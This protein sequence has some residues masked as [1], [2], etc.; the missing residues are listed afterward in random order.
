[1]DPH[2]NVAHSVPE[3]ELQQIFILLDSFQC[4][5]V[6]TEMQI[7]METLSDSDSS[8]RTTRQVL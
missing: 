7:Y 6:P 3:R 8:Q 1:M 4:Q 5:Y 2:M